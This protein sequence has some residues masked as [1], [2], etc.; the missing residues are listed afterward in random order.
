MT[1]NKLL[2]SDDRRQNFASHLPSLLRV[3]Q[4]TRHVK[5]AMF[6][7]TDRRAGIAAGWALDTFGHVQVH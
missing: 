3:F 4:I 1:D 5:I 7:T 6:A 2:V